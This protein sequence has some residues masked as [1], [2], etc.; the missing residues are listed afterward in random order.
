M[1]IMFSM[2]AFGDTPSLDPG[3]I[4]RRLTEYW[5]EL[6]PCEDAEKKDGCISFEFGDALVVIG[7]IPAP[8][9]WSSLEGP[10]AT[11]ILWPDAADILK[12]HREHAVVTVSAEVDEIE[13][14]KLLTQVTAAVAAAS[15]QALGVYW[16]NGALVISKDLF[17]E[18]AKELLPDDLPLFIWVDVRAG[19]DGDRTSAGFT[20]GMAA[21]GHMEFEA[22][23]APEPPGELRERL[24]TL[25]SYVIEN[26]PVISDGDT[27][28]ESEDERIRVAHA[29][30]SFGANAKVMRLEYEQE[31]PDRPWWKLWS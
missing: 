2:V 1:A 14:S 20:Q 8:I 9:P 28:G 6:P 5:P 18:T 10:C 4:E 31:A 7:L 26:G 21:L 29:D 25:A 3:D 23:N 30:S 22:K 15:L 24:M 17:V 27:I 12:P 16:G 13:L 19:R 11:S